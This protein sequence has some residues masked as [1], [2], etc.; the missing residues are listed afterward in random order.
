MEASTV[1]DWMHDDA[2]PSSPARARRLQTSGIYAHA[3]H[4]HAIHNC[5]RD[6]TTQARK[7]GAKL[8]ATEMDTNSDLEQPLGRQGSLRNFAVDR[9]ISRATNWRNSHW[10]AP[11]TSRAR[12]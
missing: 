4:N 3:F 11:S 9:E 1:G 7:P 5:L 12:T 10:T 2:K 6:G 8:P